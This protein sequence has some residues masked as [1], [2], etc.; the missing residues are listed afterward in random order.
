MTALKVSFIDRR[1]MK[2]GVAPKGAKQNDI[3]TVT[4]TT[5]EGDKSGSY[6]VLFVVSEKPDRTLVILGEKVSDTNPTARW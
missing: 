5:K 2:V 6:P 4:Y 3:V 1:E